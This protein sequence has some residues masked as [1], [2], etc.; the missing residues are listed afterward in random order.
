MISK[1][2]N[3]KWNEEKD[4][5]GRCINIPARDKKFSGSNKLNGSRE[6][7]KKIP[8]PLRLKLRTVKM[9]VQFY[10]KI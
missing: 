9:F 5:G 2:R 10:R 7:K 6:N 8:I 3:L 1:A 4:A